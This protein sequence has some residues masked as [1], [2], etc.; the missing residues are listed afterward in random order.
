MGAV[1]SGCDFG[2]ESSNVPALCLS[3]EEK[4]GGLLLR[5]AVKQEPHDALLGVDDVVERVLS[6]AVQHSEQELIIINNNKL[7]VTYYP[8]EICC[9]WQQRQL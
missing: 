8:G 6:F 5:G 7:E 9:S 1:S 2:A 4:F 3:D